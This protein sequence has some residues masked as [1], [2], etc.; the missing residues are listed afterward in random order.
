MLKTFRSSVQSWKMR[1][2]NGNDK[3][4]FI[5][6]GFNIIDVLAIDT[7]GRVIVIKQFYIS[8]QKKLI[9]LVGGIIDE[10]EKAQKTAQR[11]LLE[12][13]GYTT[14]KFINLGKGIK[15]KYSTGTAFYFL[16]LDA[17]KIQNPK[18]EESEDIEI[19]A[20][21]LSE[22]KKFLNQGKLQDPFAE[23]CAR[24]AIAYLDNIKK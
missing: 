2:P 17:T 8:Q 22:F 19:V 11:E 10:N 3:N 9:S 16:A 18:L 1:L 7:S 13:T 15:G 24:R 23:V 20:M 6:A 12:E 5:T 4:F 14:K 21:S